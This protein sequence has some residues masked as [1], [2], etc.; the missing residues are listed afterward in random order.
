MFGEAECPLKCFEKTWRFLLKKFP[1]VSYIK[2][3]IKNLGLDTNPD[4]YPDLDP[5]SASTDPE[6][7]F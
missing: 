1:V 4:K 3:V 7:C 5:D 2:I 6:H